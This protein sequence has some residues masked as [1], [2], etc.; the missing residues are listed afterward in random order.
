MW[1]RGER[2]NPVFRYDLVSTAPFVLS[3]DVSY[4]AADGTEK[5]VLGTDRWRRGG[6]VWRGKGILRLTSS[7]WSVAGVTKD[8]TIAAIRFSKSWVTPAGIDIVVREG[9]SQ[10][11]PRAMVAIASERFGLSAEDFATLTWLDPRTP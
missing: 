8:G 6:F 1:L 5:H 11:E 7:S 9:A 2:L 3:D 4:T 10:P